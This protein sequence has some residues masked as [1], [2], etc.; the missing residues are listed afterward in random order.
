MKL[1]LTE[2]IILY[3]QY[4]ILSKLDQESSDHYNQHCTILECGYE[5]LYDQLKE[6]FDATGLTRDE[7]REVMDILD[8]FRSISNALKRLPSDSKVQK[9]SLKFHGF[10]GNEEGMRYP[11]A[12]F[13]IREQG[14][15]QELELPDLNSHFPVL[16]RYRE[17]LAR[18]KQSG[19][20]H[21]LTEEDL[22][23]IGG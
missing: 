3:N 15:W 2:R 5:L 20:K 21:D 22:V 11:F 10:D 14:R 16:D 23:R 6:P 17:M 18:W 12:V 8:M 9:S 1:S 19:D 7:C 4:K 13:L